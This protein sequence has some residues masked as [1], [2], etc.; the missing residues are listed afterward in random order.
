MKYRSQIVAALVATI[1]LG[2]GTVACS[3]MGDS[4]ATTVGG[5]FS[6]EPAMPSDTSAGPAYRTVSGKVVKIN[7][8]YYDVMEYTGNRIRLHISGSTVKISGNKKV[9]DK[10]RAEIT[11]GGHANSIQ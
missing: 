2:L 1:A 7:V 6:G 8:S 3:S 9:G 11:R 10:I 4:P 5:G